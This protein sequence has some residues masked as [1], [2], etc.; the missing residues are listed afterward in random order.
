MAADYLNLRLN[1]LLTA[2]QAALTLV[3]SG[4][5]IPSRVY[6]S[7]GPPAVDLCDDDLLVVYLDNP[8]VRLTD[9]KADRTVQVGQFSVIPIARY[10]V[11]VWR[12]VPGPTDTSVPSAAELN[13]SALALAND[14]WALW[15]GLRLAREAGTLFP[16]GPQF[17]D[18]LIQT[19]IP[20]PPQGSMG[21]WRIRV[22]AQTNDAGP[23]I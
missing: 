23:A 21:G 13:T 22:E 16:A 14:G 12:C 4:N 19:P 20:L 2:A 18:A 9:P 10:I 8:A 1:E 17:D 3:R 7:H 6:V 5:P 15:T 11:E